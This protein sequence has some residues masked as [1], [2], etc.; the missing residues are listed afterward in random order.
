MIKANDTSLG[1][2]VSLEGETFDIFFEFVAI[3]TSV[4][5]LIEENFNGEFAD[6]AIAYAGKMAYAKSDAEKADVVKE[7]TEWIKDFDRKLSEKHG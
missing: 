5:Q 2:Q 4:R 7:F 3:I 6:T 1:C